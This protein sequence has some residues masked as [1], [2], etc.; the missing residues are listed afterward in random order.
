VTYNIF[1]EHN[2]L[3]LPCDKVFPERS[4]HGKFKTHLNYKMAVYRY[5]NFFKF[6]KELDGI[7]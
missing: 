2:P 4:L 3:K 1:R 6:S 7:S 5:S